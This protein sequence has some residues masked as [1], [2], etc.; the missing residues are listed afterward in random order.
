MIRA[1]LAS[2][3]LAFQIT[4][5]AADHKGVDWLTRMTESFDSLAYEGVFVHQEAGA[6]NSMRIRHGLIGGVEYESLEDLDG[7][8]VEVIRA[9]DSVICVFPEKEDY[10]T[11]FVPGEP[12]KR[13][14]E[15][16]QGRLESAYD[17]Q[18]I[19]E[20]QR[21]ASRDAVKLV[22]TPKDEYRHGH[23]F[24]IDKSNGFLLKHD[25]LDA[26]FKLLERI[27]FTSVDFS[28]DLK[29]EDFTPKKGSYTQ[30]F[31]EMKPQPVAND[32]TFEWLPE[33]FSLVWPYA[34]RM[35]E[36]T[37]MLL[38]SDGMSTISVFVEPSDRKRPQTLM[39]LGATIAGENSIQV[40]EQTY[41]LTLVGEVPAQT[42]QRLM[43]V[44]M[45]KP[46][47]D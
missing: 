41:L 13:F 22:L 32:W 8:R 6:M 38:L 14:R 20:P 3:L 5:F 30:Q 27:Q 25:V 33:G 42:I 23:E 45:P 21:I 17:I 39:N 34:R 15:L 29:E 24:W 7:K 9:D 31:V 36:H 46:N 47:N 1:V 11:G 28:P 18:V 37:K 19:K 16:D 35:N 44:I 2:I 43:T 12:F 40:G 26:Q 4:A 10:T